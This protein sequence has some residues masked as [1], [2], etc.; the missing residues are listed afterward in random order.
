MKLPSDL[1]SCVCIVATKYVTAVR[2]LCRLW[3]RLQ[4]QQDWGSEMQQL[5][6]KAASTNSNGSLSAETHPERRSSSFQGSPKLEIVRDDQEREANAR[7]RNGAR[8]L[9]F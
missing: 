8:C 6:F 5:L 7:I 9:Q 4:E 2:S 1:A 3:L